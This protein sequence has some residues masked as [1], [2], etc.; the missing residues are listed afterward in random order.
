MSLKHLLP[1]MLLVPAVTF[2]ANNRN[3]QIAPEQFKEGAMLESK[4]E[5]AMEKSLTGMNLSQVPML[6]LRE[7][8]FYYRQKVGAKE[9]RWFVGQPNLKAF[10]KLHA[11]S[12]KENYLRAA[13]VVS[14]RFYATQKNKAFQDESDIYFDRNYIYSPRVPKLFFMKNGRWQQLKESDRPN[15]VVI[16][17]SIAGLQSAVITDQVKSVNSLVYPLEPGMYA[18]SFTAPGRLPYVDAISV[19]E[20]QVVTLKPQLPVADTAAVAVNSPISVTE[21]SV[22]A[23]QSLED[24]ENLYDTFVKELEQNV[25]LVDT[26]EFAKTYPSPIASLKLSVTKDDDRYVEYLKKFES[27]RRSA[28]DTWVS[29]KLGGAGVV[30]K[31]LHHKLDSLQAL[32]LRGTMV[33]ARVE[34]VFDETVPER[35]VVGVRLFFG[36]EKKRVEVSWVGSVE[37]IPAGDFYEKVKN[38]SDVKFAI[39]LANNKPVWIYIKGEFVG[40]FQYR[41]E[42]LEIT[43]DGKDVAC[44][45]KFE[46]PGHIREQDEVQEW[47][48]RPVEVVKE[49]SVQK[50]ADDQDAAEKAAAAQEAANTLAVDVQANV[51]RIIRDHDRGTVA[52]I[53][54]GMFRYYGHVVSMS[55]FAIQTTEVTQQFFRD[56]M[57]KAEKEKQI[58]DRSEFVEPNKPVHNITWDNARTFCQM[59]GGDL[60]TEAQ[61]EFAGRADNNEGALWNL[62]ENPDPSQYAIFRENSYKMGEKNSAYGPQAVASRKANPWGLYD[63]SGNVAEWTRDSYFMFSFWVESSNPTGAMMGLHKVYKGGSWKDKESRL[64]L[65]ERDDEDPRYWS[66]AIGFRC[67]FSRDVFEPKKPVQDSKTVEMDAKRVLEESKRAMAEAEARNAAADARK[68]EAKKAAEAEKAE[69]NTKAAEES[70]TVESEESKKSDAASKTAEVKEKSAKA[71]AELAE[72]AKKVEEEKKGDDVQK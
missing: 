35:P 37:G 63:M 41:Y 23:A 6:P 8:T 2:A 22:A 51:P 60:P 64:N 58:K 55:P 67:A 32:P 34:P 28:K 48:N 31:A 56:V 10:E 9:F 57:M 40:R 71:E 4:Q 7:N 50:I 26:S 38:G 68:A 44:T 19:Q 11:F 12:L 61:W 14:L 20:G 36:E 33:P 39:T 29:N 5:I 25:S 69:S 70:K 13:E 15:I 72:E 66:N 43:V 46:L 47:L 3:F 17:T 54:S 21:A 27:T 45:G 1:V 42:K 16:D 53:D 59:L 30:S 65:T 18:F 24:V 49:V 62:D 52:L